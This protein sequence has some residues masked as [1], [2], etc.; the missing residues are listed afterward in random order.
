[1]VEPHK[2]TSSIKNGIGYLVDN[3]KNECCSWCY[4]RFNTWII[5]NNKKMCPY[6]ERE[7]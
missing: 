5:K 3:F 2:H 4:K 1:M 7:I 6:C